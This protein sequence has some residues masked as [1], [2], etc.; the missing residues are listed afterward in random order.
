[1]IFSVFHQM[2]IVLFRLDLYMMVIYMYGIGK[3]RKNL[4]Q[5]N[6]HV[7]YD[8]LTLEFYL[9]FK[10]FL[11]NRFVVLPLLKMEVILLLLEI[12]M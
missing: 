2:L 12:V 9:L 11:Y 3:I 8:N 6:V 1:M 7:L 5:I 4:H 10:F